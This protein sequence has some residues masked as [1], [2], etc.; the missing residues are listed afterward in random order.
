MLGCI[1]VIV[2]DQILAPWENVLNFS[3]FAVRVPRS[4]LPRLPEILRAIPEARVQEMQRADWEALAAW[5]ALRPL[6]RRR[7]AAASGF[8][9]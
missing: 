2:Q 6:E 3:A 1:P 9:A 5:V 4:D 8:T 7:L